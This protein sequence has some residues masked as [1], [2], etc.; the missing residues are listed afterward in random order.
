MR[1]W[2][3]ACPAVLDSAQEPRISILHPSFGPQGGG[4]LVSLRGTH[5]SAGSSWRVTINGSECPLNGQPRYRPAIVSALQGLLAQV[6]PQGCPRSPTVPSSSCAVSPARA[7][8]RFG[9]QLPLPPAWV[10]PLWPC[11]S[12]ARSSWL[13]CPSS[14][15]PTPPFW[16]SSPTAAMG[17]RIGMQGHPCPP[18]AE[19]LGTTNTLGT[20]CAWCPDRG[21]LQ[22]LDAH[23]HRHPPG[24]S[25]SCQDPI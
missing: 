2:L 10:Q 24:L 11:G 15:A 7:M 14:T 19:V 17:E 21:P 16:P 23:A 4:T 9:A 1:C 6:W 12:M 8:G 25:V 13:H 22:G 20:V 5:L 18:R 3:T